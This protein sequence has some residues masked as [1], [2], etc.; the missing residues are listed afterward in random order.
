MTTGCDISSLDAGLSASSL[1][2]V[3]VVCP[4]RRTVNARVAIFPLPL[5]AG[6]AAYLDVPARS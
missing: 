6:V 2:N 4:G 1:T 3:I 5:K